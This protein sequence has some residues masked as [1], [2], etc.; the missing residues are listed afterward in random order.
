MTC[1]F[2]LTL[3]AA[4]TAAGLTFAATR[5]GITVLPP[6]L[7][8]KCQGAIKV[9]SFIEDDA[10]IKKILAHLGLWD[11]RKHDPPQSNEVHIPTFET[12]LTNDYTYWQLPPID[13]WTP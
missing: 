1:R 10:L 4:R 2:G 9:I 6:L 3:S 5:L 11:T 13:Y 12:E 7:C 8:P